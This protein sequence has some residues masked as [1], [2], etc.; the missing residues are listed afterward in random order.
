MTASSAYLERGA[1][2]RLVRPDIPH[3]VSGRFRR[4][5]TCLN[6]AM[7]AIFFGVPWLRWDRGPDLADLAV[8]LDLPGRRLFA[9]GLEFWPQDLPIAVGVMIGAALALFYATTLAGRVWC[10]FACPQTVW[11]DLL[12]S[13]DRLITRFAGRGAAERRMRVAVWFSI[14]VATAFGFVAWFND[15]TSLPALILS[16]DASSAVYASLLVLTATTFTLALYARERVCLHMCPWPRFQAALLDRESLVVTYQHWRGEPRGKARLPLR[17]NIAEPGLYALARQAS[18]LGGQLAERGDCIDCTRC[19]TACPTGVDIRKGLQMGCI[20]CGL[21]ID[22]C[23]EVM[24]K[25]GRP[26]G[27]IRF[28]GDPAGGGRGFETPPVSWLRGKALAFAG[29]ALAALSISVYGAATM[30]GLM[31]RVEP[32]RNPSYV[33]MSDGSVRN[34]YAVRILHRLRDLDGVLI[35]A[36]GLDGASLGLGTETREGDGSARIGFGSNRSAEERVLV[37]LPKGLAAGGRRPFDF[38]LADEHGR[39]LLRVRSEFWGPER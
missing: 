7:L 6:V 31:V 2:A 5:K 15:V 32:Q 33:L 22:A 25:L 19:V 28:D 21:C 4:I 14:A 3:G 18:D 8:L 10:G 24:A 9:F 1:T 11:S 16:G 34:D 20:G 29:A 37:T 27:L 35:S 17:P 23:D 36:A 38:V 26:D 12:F 30:P 39:E 13:V